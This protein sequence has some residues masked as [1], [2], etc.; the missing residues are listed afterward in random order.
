M[1]IPSDMSFRARKN[2]SAKRQDLAPP[3]N[4]VRNVKGKEPR[5]SHRMVAEEA[6]KAGSPSNVNIS[7]GGLGICSYHL[8]M[9]GFGFG[10]FGENFRYVMF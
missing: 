4:L 6:N 7:Y 9:L 1:P 2:A 8:L 10:G 5:A 3:K